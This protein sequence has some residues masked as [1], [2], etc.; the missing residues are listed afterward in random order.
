MIKIRNRK[1]CCGCGACEQICPRRCIS[2]MPDKEGFLY[3]EINSTNCVNCG[4]CEKAC[5]Y[6]NNKN[7]ND[8]L[9]SQYYFIHNNEEIRGKSSSGGVFICF[10]EEIIK[11][12]GVVFGACF[13]KNFDVEISYAETLEDCWKFVGS[14][15]VQAKV[16]NAYQIAKKFLLENRI[17]LFTGTPCQI[18]GLQHYL[19]RKYDNLVKL[20]FT[21]HAIPS[22]SIWKKYLGEIRGKHIIRSVN[23]RDKV[24][25]GW[26][27][28]GLTITGKYNDSERTLVSEGNRQ[29]SY[30]K[31][32]LRYLY[33]R[34]SCSNCIS[35]CFSSSSDIMIGDFWNVGKYHS[36]S[37]FNDNK[38]VSIV[39]A[40]SEKGNSLIHALGQY[41][42]I[43]RIA[44]E[45]VEMDKSHDCILKSAS[46]HPFRKVFFFLNRIG[47]PLRL[48]IWIC[49]EPFSI[50]KNLL[51]PFKRLIT[52]L[53]Q[54]ALKNE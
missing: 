16:G 36:E 30:M 31:G 44:Q 51:R 45:E 38:G 1:E 12:K 49:L 28:Y 50:L 29:N 18:N 2:M 4:L 11:R 17:V 48:N 10:A 42:K 47:L 13:D 3:P 19:G 21:C 39:L 25:S 54:H 7:K 41:G 6:I 23:F 43:E 27:N 9:Q 34:P 24:V 20:D 35:R 40:I 46:Q 14:K 15:Y 52:K 26:N 33:D 8:S 22:P 32:F 37:I 53:K 5:Q